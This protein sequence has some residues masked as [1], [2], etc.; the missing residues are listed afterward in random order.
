MRGLLKPLGFAP[1]TERLPIFGLGCVGGAVGLARAAVMA[2]A[3]PG[4]AVL[5]LVVELC[6]LWFRRDDLGKSNIV[7]TALFGDGAA[8]AVLEAG[9]DGP[10]VSARGE[11]TFQTR[12]T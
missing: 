10:R 12:S 7:A 9:A 3:M 8:A 4:R 2:Q 5:L 1:T 6:A 11:H